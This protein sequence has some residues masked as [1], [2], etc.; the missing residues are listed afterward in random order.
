MSSSIFDPLTEEQ[1]RMYAAE[2]EE[3]FRWISKIVATYS[4]YTLTDVDLISSEL[5]QELAEIGQFAEIAYTTL[6]IQFLID[7]HTPLSQPDFPLENY[8]ALINTVPVE[9]LRGNVADLPAYIAHRPSTSQLIVAIA[10]TSSI[11][12][13]LQ[14]LRFFKVSHPSGKG[15]VHSGFWAMYQG[16]KDQLLPAVEKAITDH[17]PTEVVL[18][19]HSM[20]GSI[21]YLLCMDL[22]LSTDLNL[23]IAV[24]GAPRTGDAALV[25]YYR[26]LVASFRKTHSFKD[27]SVK[28]WNDGVPALPPARMGFRHFCTEPIYTVGGRLYK[29]PPTESEHALFRVQ[30]SEKVSLFPKGGHNYYNGR[31][32]ERFTRRISWLASSRPFDDGWEERYRK[33]C[34][35]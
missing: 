34:Q 20:G 2:K 9:S 15:F 16:L 25:D 24:F 31:D 1:L 21:A 3:N 35:K 19:G 29:T 4:P 18:T 10:G 17:S 13:V 14:D 32:L 7:N 30:A 28:G 8:T 23:K 22:L 33:E 12:H 6:P 26:D 11:K 27:Y 5:Y